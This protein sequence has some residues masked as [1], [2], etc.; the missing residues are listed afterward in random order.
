MEIRMADFSA[1]R[2][3]FLV[4][5]FAAFAPL[6][7]NKALGPEAIRENPHLQDEHENKRRLHN[8]GLFFRSQRRLEYPE[9]IPWK[10]AW[11]IS[12]RKETFFALPPGI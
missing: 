1:Q 10:S 12:A 6:R 2:K 5:P 7:D 11:R 9:D 3:P 8:L 4:S